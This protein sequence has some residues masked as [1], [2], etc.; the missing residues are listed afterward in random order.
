MNFTGLKMYINSYL[1]I[2]KNVYGIP[3]EYKNNKVCNSRLPFGFT[4]NNFLALS[5]RLRLKGK[6]RIHKMDVDNG[7]GEVTTQSLAM[8]RHCNYLITFWDILWLR[9]HMSHCE[10]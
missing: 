10:T 1:N 3:L 4:T 9:R 7:L 6:L 5:Q 8:W 2:R